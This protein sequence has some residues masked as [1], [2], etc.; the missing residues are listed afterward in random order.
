MKSY[1]TNI[2]YSIIAEIFIWATA[3]IMFMTFSSCC[4]KI[5]LDS[6]STSTKDTFTTKYIYKDS[7]VIIPEN[8]VY[9]DTIKVFI[10]S[11]GRAQLPKLK[12][13]SNNAYIQAEIVNSVLSLKGGCDSLE[14]IL[15]NLTIENTHLK[16]TKS[17]K[18]N[19]TV[20][21]VIPKFYKFCTYAFICTCII[22]LM[23][24]YFKIFLGKR[25]I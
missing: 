5:I 3:L 10:D 1:I 6:S 24:L 19:T 9:I 16:E 21:K 4:P 12:A 17:S 15:K 25:V 8:V 2:K 7:I 14:V 20:V 18:E 22:F 11:I 23:Y 13:K